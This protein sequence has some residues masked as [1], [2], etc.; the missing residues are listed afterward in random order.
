MTR[1]HRGF[2]LIELLVVIAII[3]VL[4]A[5]LLPA[6]QSAREAARR[7]QCTN[8][9]KQVALGLHN[10]ASATG[11]FPPGHRTAVYGT[12]QLF[13]LPYIEQQAL[14]NHYNMDGRYMEPQAG[15]GVARG[16]RNG[17]RYGSVHNRTVTTTLINA[18]ICPSDGA[19]PSDPSLYSGVTWHNY[20][21]NFGNA[22]I[23]Q[24]LGTVPGGYTVGIY[25]DVA[26][27]QGAPFS[28]SDDTQNFYPSRKR[29][30]DFASIRDG[31]SN[32]LLVGEVIKGKGGDLRGFTWWGDAVSTSTYLTPNSSL[33]DVQNSAGYCK[34]PLEDNP[35][36]VAA[37]SV[38]PP[39]YAFRSRHP[40][41]VNMGFADGSVRFIKNTINL[42]TWRALGT[43]RG[44]E[45]ISADQY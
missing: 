24:S 37:T 42:Y 7:A 11:S 16:P 25:P 4:I 39:T 45:V 34:Y 6:V 23:Y 31:T 13:V 1:R 22:D 28:D 32:T 5:L 30:Y 17:I 12:F 19:M 36:C 18:L 8:N 10:Y 40:G 26:Q 35:P 38:M 33:P 3:G 29:V 2:T 44:G 43:T 20:T 14:Y 9:L 15:G 41:G 21:C 27:W